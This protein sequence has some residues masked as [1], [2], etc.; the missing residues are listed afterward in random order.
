MVIKHDKVKADFLGAVTL[1]MAKIAKL[2]EQQA[3]QVTLVV[4]NPPASTGEARG[5]DLIP[6]SGG[7]PGVDSGSPLQYSCLENS[8]DSG[9]WPTTAHGVAKSWR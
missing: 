1:P 7:S 5:V 6:G 4:K 2:G 3:Y 9:T 8:M